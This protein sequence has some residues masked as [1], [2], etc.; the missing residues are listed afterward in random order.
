M[1]TSLVFESGTH[2]S[3]VTDADLG[4]LLLATGINPFTR[5]LVQQWL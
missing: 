4:D 2:Y 3:K 5:K 1:G